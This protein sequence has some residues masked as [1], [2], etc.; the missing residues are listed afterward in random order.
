M[1]ED[2]HRQRLRLRAP[3]VER[4][5]RNVEG[6]TLGVAEAVVGVREAVLQKQMLIV[7]VLGVSNRQRATLA[8]ALGVRPDYCERMTVVSPSLCCLD[9]A[10][11]R[12]DQLAP[13]KPVF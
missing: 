12:L 4:R 6:E 3:G 5:C 10:L 11:V 9:R 2:D 7:D 1:Q 13:G 8:S